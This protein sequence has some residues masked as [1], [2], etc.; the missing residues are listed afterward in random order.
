[1]PYQLP[2]ISSLAGSK[3]PEVLLAKCQ[4]V[5]VGAG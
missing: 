3:E 2:P 5:L 1:M 4:P